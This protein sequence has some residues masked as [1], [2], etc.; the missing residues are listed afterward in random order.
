MNFELLVLA[1]RLDDEE[2]VIEQEQLQIGI[3]P[4]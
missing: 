3:I 2:S 1:F 4:L